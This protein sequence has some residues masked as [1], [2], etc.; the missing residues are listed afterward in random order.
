MFIILRKK[1]LSNITSKLNRAY[2]LI[3]FS[4]LFSSVFVTI[5]IQ[6]T[7]N[8]FS[9][10]LCMKRVWQ[11]ISL[12]KLFIA[13]RIRKTCNNNHTDG[14]LYGKIKSN[15]IDSWKLS[16]VA[17]NLVYEHH[18]DQHMSQQIVCLLLLFF[19][20]V[21]SFF[22]SSLINQSKILEFV[23]S[24]LK[25]CIANAFGFFVCM[26]KK[27]YRNTC[28]QH[29]IHRAHTERWAYEQSNHNEVTR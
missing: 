12:K 28:R 8:F 19:F 26:A 18:F 15:M 10:S 16:I 4:S 17:E 27:C 22:L 3:Q 6:F 21:Y 29:K 2:I 23:S 25:H 5:C 20:A 14:I 1:N 11:I 24:I 9:L 7:H 13:Y